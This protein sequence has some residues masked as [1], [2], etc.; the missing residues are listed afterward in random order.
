MRDDYTSLLYV[1]EGDITVGN[2]HYRLIGGKLARLSTRGLIRIRASV[3]CKV[4]VMT[5]K[6]IGE[7]IVQQGPFV[8]NTTE[9]I[10]Q[11]VRE[12]S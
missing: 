6:P 12:Y 3:G 11:A 9:E 2:S 8:M 7:P 1:Y 5:R 4:L 10:Q